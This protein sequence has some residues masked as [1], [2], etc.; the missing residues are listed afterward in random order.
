VISIDCPGA[1]LCDIDRFPVVGLCDID[2]VPVNVA[3]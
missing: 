2:N 3:L 1:G